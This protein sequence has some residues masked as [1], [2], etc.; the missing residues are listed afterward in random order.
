MKDFDLLESVIHF[1]DEYL[2]GNITDSPSKFSSLLD[3]YK[4]K[5]NRCAP[6]EPGGFTEEEWC[7]I[8]ETCIK[9]NKTVEDLLHIE[10]GDDCVY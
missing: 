4:K 7:T 8:L 6:T 1:T 10:Y 5:F 9:E 3:A 2:K